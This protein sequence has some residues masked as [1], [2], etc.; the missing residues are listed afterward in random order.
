MVRS[1]DVVI[2]KLDLKLSFR[3]DNYAIISTIFEFILEACQGCALTCCVS[4]KNIT[5]TCNIT[6][7][8]FTCLTTFTNL[9]SSLV[10]NI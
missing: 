1:V 2:R 5:Y 3:L 8:I 4:S 6:H 9:I 10:Q 7:K